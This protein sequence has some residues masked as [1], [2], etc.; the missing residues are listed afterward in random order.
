MASMAPP[1]SGTLKILDP[2][3]GTGILS[4]A[5]VN[6]LLS[7]SVLP[8]HIS[9]T[10]YEVDAYLHPYLESTLTLCQKE[11]LAAGVDFTF[12]ILGDD[13]IEAGT[14]LVTSQK[15]MSLFE[16]AMVVPEFD[17]VITN[18]PIK[19]FPAS[20]ALENVYER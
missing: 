4:A 13:F 8:A 2:G 16:P 6:K 3:A 14:R 9:I 7:D 5:L 20:Q 10:V 1:M 18:P 17:L 12:S 19:K 15:Q 11:C